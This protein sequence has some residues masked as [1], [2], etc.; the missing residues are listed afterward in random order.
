MATK[1]TGVYLPA[2][3]KT[4]WIKF[5]WRGKPFRENAA[6]TDWKKASELRTKRLGE[7]AGGTFTGLEL[8][9]TK[10][11]ELFDGLL[12]DY[13]INDKSSIV[14]VE[15]R[16]NL[17]LK[18]F[19]GHYRA[20]EVTTDLINRYIEH[21]LDEGTANSS[22]NR[23]LA[24]LKRSYNLGLQST[25]PKVLRVPYMPH[26]EEDNVRLGFVE[27][28]VYEKLVNHFA[29]VGLW[30]RGMLEMGYTYGL[31]VEAIKS[32]KVGWVD[33]GHRT[34]VFPPKAMKNKKTLTVKMTN[35]VYQLLQ[36]CCQ[37]KGADDFV[38]T[39][40]LN[41]RHKPIVDFRI[42]WENGCKAAGVP[43][44]LFHDLRRTAARN[45]R[46]AGVAESVIMQIG[47]WLTRSVFLRYAIVDER[48]IADAVQMLEAHQGQKKVKIQ[49]SGTENEEAQ[50]A[51]VG[52]TH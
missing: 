3:S 7:V 24:A 46:R 43:G 44:L 36:Q 41:G 40:F 38:F 14:D 42:T 5:G 37:G 47:N 35:T 16:I 8:K 15:T 39:R 19:L 23:E 12:R 2:G 31:R 4:L 52:L 49:P 33:L 1:Y 20:N 13:R 22:I 50:P 6:T 29:G 45:L 34:L 18:P 21:R 9:K 51:R 10:V 25:P 11:A 27:D 17:H 32:M 26:L 28:H 48:D 30:M